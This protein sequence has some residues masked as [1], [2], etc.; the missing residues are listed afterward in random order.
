MRR[1]LRLSFGP[2]FFDKLRPKDFDASIPGLDFSKTSIDGSVSYA[3]DA[4]KTAVRLGKTIG[5]LP[6]TQVCLSKADGGLQTD[7]RRP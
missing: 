2:R 4:D 3:R 1:H 5:R 6:L 7:H